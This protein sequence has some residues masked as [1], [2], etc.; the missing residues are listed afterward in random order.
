MHQKIKRLQP[1]STVVGTSE[2]KR[3]CV[4]PVHKTEE[5]YYKFDEQNINKVTQGSGLETCV[6]KDTKNSEK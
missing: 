1:S 2:S 5:H 3:L 6:F 4:E